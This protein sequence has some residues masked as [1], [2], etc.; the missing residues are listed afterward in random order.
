[1]TPEQFGHHIQADV[2]RWTA[3]A[4]DRKIQLDD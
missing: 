1:M 4:R 3:L 2:A